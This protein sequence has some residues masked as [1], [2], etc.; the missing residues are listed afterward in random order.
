MERQKCECCG[1]TMSFRWCDQHGVGACITCG[2]P[3]TI[4]HY[5]GPGTEGKRIDKPPEVAL[6]PSGIEI[7]KRYWAEKKRRVFPGCYD[8]G[9]F[10]RS[11]S[12][13]TTYSGATHEDIELFN[14]WYNAN[15][16]K[17]VEAESAE[18]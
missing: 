15:Y 4:Y 16:P 8:M 18:A 13:G 11:R 12:T 1:E 5:E 6:S 2:L 14:E 10:G 3:Y 7:A 17:A 9:F